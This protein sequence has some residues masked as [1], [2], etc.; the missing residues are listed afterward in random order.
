M[1]IQV[2]QPSRT[3]AIGRAPSAQ[4]QQSDVRAYARPSVHPSY[5]FGPTRYRGSGRLYAR[6]TMG[7]S[8][9][10]DIEVGVRGIGGVPVNESKIWVACGLIPAMLQCFLR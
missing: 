9:N 10:E 5:R 6:S 3:A 1:G 2:G 4:H 8:I 7:G